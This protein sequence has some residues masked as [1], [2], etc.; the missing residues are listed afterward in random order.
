M[1]ISFPID[2]PTSVG[3]VDLNLSL[4]YAI[5]RSEAEFS[6]VEQIVEHD[7]QM[8]LLEGDFGRI[9]DRETAEIMQNFLFSL[10]GKKG[11]FLFGDP[12]ATSPRGSWGGTPVVDGAGQTGNV[13][14][15]RGFPNST[16]NVAMIGDYIQLGS[17][18]SSKL[19]KIVHAN[20]NSDG[21][22]KGVLNIVPKL[23]TS[24]ADGATIVFNNARGLFRL[25][26]NENGYNLKPSTIYSGRFVATEALSGN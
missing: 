5:S 11:T 3:L 13:L 23:R 19:H 12:A 26:S 22:G 1:T 24:P 17:G 14:N 21:T 2:F 20:V 9:G 8:W 10:Q 7:G 4:R 15:V 16:N 18:S 25:G 6:F